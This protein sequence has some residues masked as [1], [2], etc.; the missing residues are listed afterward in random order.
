M[1]T[2]LDKVIDASL[3]CGRMLVLEQMR[4][5]RMQRNYPLSVLSILFLLALVLVGC[6]EPP[7]PTPT[8]EVDHSPLVSPIEPSPIE[9]PTVVPTLSTSR[10][11][12]GCFDPNE[13][14]LIKGVVT[15]VGDKY[16]YLPEMEG[17]QDAL[18]LVKYGGRW[19]C[20]EEDAIQNGF[21]KAPQ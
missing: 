16:Y 6:A 2:R 19:F 15:G 20:S 12:T 10:C 17:Y 21:E 14:C 5:D 3:D 7:S 4:R 9:T 8:P 18:L 13:E 1:L 11:P